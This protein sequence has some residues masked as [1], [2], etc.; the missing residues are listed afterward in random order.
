MDFVMP[1]CI[2]DPPTSF[3]RVNNTVA[4]EY[5]SQIE[6]K[7]LTKAQVQEAV[8]CCQGKPLENVYSFRYLGS[9][10]TANGQEDKD[11]KRRVGMTMTRRGQLRSLRDV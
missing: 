7:K 9:M 1:A 3:S 5:C 11:I 4:L 2:K 8:V 6:K 10:F